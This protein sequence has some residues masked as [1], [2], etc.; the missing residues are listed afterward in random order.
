M[1]TDRGAFYLPNQKRIELQKMIEQLREEL[2]RITEDKDLTDPE[3][4]AASRKSDEALNEYN[5]LLMEKWE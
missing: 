2:L 3:V 1:F 5:R 4:I